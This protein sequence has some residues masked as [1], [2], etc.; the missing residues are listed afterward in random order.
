MPTI[1]ISGLP[2]SGTT[3]ISEILGKDLHLH[4]FSTGLIFRD[5][6]KKYGIRLDE[7]SKHCETSPAVD[8]QIEKRQIELLRKGSI[9][10]ESRLGGWLAH[11]NNID[12]YKIWLEAEMRERAKRVAK[13]ERIS[14]D[15][16][17]K[18][19]LRREESEK[20]RYRAYYGIDLEDLS[21]YDSVINTR[22]KS[23]KEIEA[24]VLREFNVK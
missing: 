2:G 12:A 4:I 13:R 11:L 10:L 1:T 3:T 9:I 23:P 21:I 16:S 20:K 6:S 7:F 14:I 19:I 22:D 24:A 17:I 18:Q 8:N 15:K 5:L